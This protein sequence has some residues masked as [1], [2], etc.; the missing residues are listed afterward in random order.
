MIR[1][2]IRLAIAGGAAQ[3]ARFAITVAGAAVG[4]A[5]LFLVVGLEPAIVARGERIAQRV[6]VLHEYDIDTLSRD[7]GVPRDGA[8]LLTTSTHWVDGRELTVVDAASTGPG[9]PTPPGLAGSPS[10]DEVYVSP[11]LLSHSDLVSALA[12]GRRVAGVIGDA[13]LADSDEL[14]MWRGWN[15]RQLRASASDVALIRAFPIPA[16]SRSWWSSEVARLVGVTGAATVVLVP[17]AVFIGVMVRLGSSQRQ[18][19]MGSLALAGATRQQL[20]Q[21]ASVEGALTGLFAV[22]IGWL[23]SL[24]GREIVARVSIGGHAWFPSDFQPRPTIAIVV[25]ALTVVVSVGASVI[26]VEPVARSPLSVAS[27]SMRDSTSTF[28]L[29]A[30]LAGLVLIG[31]ASWLAGGLSPWLVATLTSS[32]VALFVI[33]VPVAGPR[34]VQIVSRFLAGRSSR[35]D[36]MIAARRL[37]ADPRAAVRA[38]SGVVLAVFALTLVHG[39]TSGNLGTAQDVA[40]P[41]GTSALLEPNGANA[42]PVHR[43]R[44]HVVRLP[45]VREV[46]VVQRMLDSEG[47]PVLFADCEALNATGIAT[48]APCTAAGWS[49]PSTEQEH[50]QTIGQ[51]AT[52]F[53]SLTSDNIGRIIPPE[54]SPGVH[55]GGDLIVNRSLLGRNL[56]SRAETTLL[57]LTGDVDVDQVHLAV[58]KYLPGHELVTPQT[59]EISWNRALLDAQH[60]ITLLSALVMAVGLASLV[61]SLSG[62]LLAQRDTIRHLRRAGLTSEGLLATSLWQVALPVALLVP[63]AAFGGLVIAAA[64]THA[65]DGRFQPSLHFVGTVSAGSIVASLVVVAASSPLIERASRPDTPNGE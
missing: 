57:A 59:R 56:Q 38:S 13:G 40:F 11:A 45:G 2:G 51:F 42:E 30:P 14:A 12:V 34:L 53:P 27:R 61:T 37:E 52:L 63:V 48:L 33:G 54:R 9:S 49:H 26:A 43:F 10:P 24:V 19:R 22:S 39:Y 4:V 28:R 35:A 62:G 8:L 32:G 17:V 36:M 1:L 21:L 25:T 7:D 44:Q 20:R 23:L 16:S 58:A 65:V 29:V 15:P 6:P 18:R 60:A 41:S 47:H 46:A 55:L 64:F 5:I 31:L 3:V 50:P